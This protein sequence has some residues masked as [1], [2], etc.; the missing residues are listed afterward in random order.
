MREKTTGNTP[1]KLPGQ[2]PEKQSGQAPE[3]LSFVIPCYRSEPTIRAVVDEL[4]AAM[5]ERSAHDYEI[6][7]VD[8][9]SPDGVYRVIQELAAEDPRVLGLS[10]ARN[11]GQHSALLAGMRACTG[12]VCVC[13]DDDGQTPANELWNLVDALNDEV[14]VVYASYAQSHKKHSAFR[15]FG[16]ALNEKMLEV[17]LKK[18][19]KLE[20]TSFFAAKRYVIEEACGYT[21]PFP[22]AIGLILRT[23][24]RIVNVPVRHRAREVGRSGYTLK[25]LVSLWV[26]GFTAFSVIPLRIA[27]MTG[28]GFSV[29]GFVYTVYLIIRKLVDPTVPMGYSSTMAALLVIGG[30][31]MLLVGMLGEYV[32]RIYVSL[33]N[34][35]QY[36]V[37]SRTDGEKPNGKN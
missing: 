30:I 13:L 6:I 17:I 35:P 5:A 22:Y 32:G 23:T 2:A 10:F 36:V 1:E 21:N 25:K 33:N 24:N 19:K 7:L 26:N 15:N 31:L 16:S 34:N 14:D 27:T 18:P 37:R 8:D 9:C 12:D 4:R 20:I 28:F 3:K 29:F 11:F